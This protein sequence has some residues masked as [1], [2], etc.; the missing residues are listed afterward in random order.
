MKPPKVYFLQNRAI[1]AARAELEAKAIIEKG[2]SLAGQLNLGIESVSKLS[3]TQRETLINQLIEIGATVKN[4]ILYA[5]DRGSEK[6]APF[7]RVSE[8]Q[9]RM[10]DALAARV[11]W[12]EIDGYLRF[13]HKL[14][15]APRPRNSKE[16]TT[17][18]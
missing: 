15:K 11:Q 18:A 9:L 16:V 8:E 10:V 3:L 13:C 2:R 7:T 6:I 12:K 5:S 14:L 1:H 17:S 4:P